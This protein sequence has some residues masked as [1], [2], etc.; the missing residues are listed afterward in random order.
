MNRKGRFI[1]RPAAFYHRAILI[2]QNQIRHPDVC[3]VHAE[4]I[5]PEMIR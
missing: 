1:H 3:E 2:H 4:R 5:H